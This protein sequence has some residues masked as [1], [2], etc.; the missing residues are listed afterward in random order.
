MTSDVLPLEKTKRDLLND[1]LK[2]SNFP[3][4]WLTTRFSPLSL[5]LQRSC[6]VC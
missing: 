4:F 3:P 2:F 1:F 6:D 5:G